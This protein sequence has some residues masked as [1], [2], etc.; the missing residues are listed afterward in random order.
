LGGEVDLSLSVKTEYSTVYLTVDGQIGKTLK[1]NEK[2]IIESAPFK[3]K[4]YPHPY[5]SYFDLLRIK[6]K[7]GKR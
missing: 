7:W 2:V 5:R 4:V 1:P 6:L 3:L